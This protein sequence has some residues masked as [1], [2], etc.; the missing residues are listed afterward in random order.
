MPTF[1][2]PSRDV[3][4]L[5]YNATTP[6]CDE[7]REAALPFLS[8]A[9]GNPSS[10]YALGREA[11][12]ALE[13]ARAQ[14][15]ALVNAEPDE[16]VFTGCATE[17]NNLAL[18]GAVEDWRG[19]KLVTTSV[20]HP[21]VLNPALYLVEQGAEVVFLEVDE[22]G[23][24]DPATA[25]RTAAGGCALVSVMHANN[26]TGTILPVAEI[27]EALGPDVLLHADCSQSLGKLPVDV[28][29]LGVDLATFAGHKVYAPKGV[30]A[31]Y[32]RRGVK[33]APLFHGGGQERG[34][35]SGTENVALAAAFGAACEA[36]RRALPGSR[37]RL[38]DLS[39]R[40]HGRLAERV[41]GLL[42]NGHPEQRLPNTVNLS[43][44]GV[45][46]EAV[47]SSCPRLAASTGAACHGP[48]VSVSHVLAAMGLSRDRA[49]GAV[50]LSVGLPTVE[51][52][53]DAAAD[54]LAAA[55]ESLTGRRK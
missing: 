17:S 29:A 18:K 31:L 40:L 11:R 53:V 50:R 14:V 28:A 22:T 1:S 7:A 24:P 10:G 33:L 52:E 8:D 35:R 2:T 13:T 51:D 25:A 27:R 9:F 49:A 47:L 43:F 41:P 46:G 21:S 15:A 6:V 48:E 3:I 26:E 38:A 45:T 4:Y 34:L 39:A 5:D 20:E 12:R 37:K 42:L 19:K 32:V 36:A 16:I 55:W 54:M 44:P 30:G 23:R